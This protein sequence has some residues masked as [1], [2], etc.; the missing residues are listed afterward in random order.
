MKNLKVVFIL[1]EFP[2]ISETFILNLI[3]GLI[4]LGIDIELIALQ[5]SND[6]KVHADVIKYDLMKKVYYLNVPKNKFIR[7]L[8]ALPIIFLNLN[9]PKKIISSLNFFTYGKAVFSL[10]PLYMTNHFISLNKNFDIIHCHFGQRGLIGA[11][12]KD[13]GITGRLVTSFYGGDIFVYPKIAGKE[14]YKHLFEIGD[15]F[16]TTSNFARK[17][18]INLGIDEKK[19]KVLPVGFKTKKFQFMKRIRENDKSTVLI[20]VA[21]L[22]EKKGYVYA[23]QA[24]KNLINQGKKIKYIIVGDGELREQLENL[25]SKLKIKKHVFFKGFATEDEV[26]ELYRKSDIFILHSITASDGAVETQSLVLQEAQKT[27]LPIVSTNHDGIPDGVLENKSGFLVPEKDVNLFTEKIKILIDSPKLREKFGKAGERFVR[28]RYE[29][30][31]L[32]K[33][34]IKFYSSLLK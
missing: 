17:G 8:K 31:N 32:N 13:I 21:R 2:K 27:G 1:G 14:I 6:K 4:D 11:V 18:V 34:L 26:I 33:K 22:V 25:V 15:L 16:L 20:T 28:E 24:I 29:I 7:F 9:K 23:L 30:K 5:R 12:L 10:Y 3:T 19:I